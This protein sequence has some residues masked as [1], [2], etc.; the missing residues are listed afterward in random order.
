MEMGFYLLERAGYDEA[1]IQD[2]ARTMEYQDAYNLYRHDV[3]ID[4]SII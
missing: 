3:E 1:T 4:N 2:I